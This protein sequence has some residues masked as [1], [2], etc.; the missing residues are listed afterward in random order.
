MLT[1]AAPALPPARESRSGL[2]AL[3]LAIAI[4]SPAAGLGAQPPL[5]VRIEATVDA[6]T[7]PTAGRATLQLRFLA[8]EP[9]TSPYAVRVE[10]RA[11]RRTFLRRDHAPPQPTTRWAAG[12]ATTYDLPLVFPLGPPADARGPIEVFVGLVDPATD[13]VARLTGSAGLVRVAT[14]VFEAGAAPDVE[15]VV[16][17]ALTAAA[18]E[19]QT[20]WDQLEYAFRRVD[21]YPAKAKLQKALLQVGRMPPA[22]LSFEETDIVQRRIQEERARYLRLCAGR[23][24]DRGRLLGALL[25]LDEVGGRL[26]EEADRAVLGALAGAQRVTQDRAAIADKVFALSGEQRDEVAQLVD[27]HPGGKE[28]LAA[29]VR[30]ARDP[31]HR[32]VGRELVRTLEFTP[33]LRAEARAAREQIERAWLADV[34]AD[35]RAE[36][37]AALQHP[38]WART[39]VRPSHRFVLIGPQRLLDGVPADSLLRFDLAYLYLTDLFG[40]VPNPAGDRVTV[41][42]KELWDFGGGQGGGKV[43][44]IGRADPQAEA[45]RVDTGLLYHEL[46]HC[47]EDVKPVYAGFKEGLADFGAAFALLE[48]GQVAAG[49][50]AIG[51][52]QRAFLQDYLERDLEYWRIPNYGPSAG[53]L[54]HFVIAHGRDGDGYRWDLYRRFFR[55]YAACPVGDARAPNIARAFAHHLV[56]AFGEAAFADLQRFRWPLLDSDLEAVRLEQL[57]AAKRQLGPDLVGFAG[58]PVPRDRAAAEL[59]RRGAGLDAHAARLGIVRDWWIVGP[60]RRDGVDV[61]TYRFPP[62]LEIDLAARYESIQHSPTWRRP[63][64]RPVTVRG[65]GWIDFEFAY[66]EDSAFYALT[67]VRAERDLDAWFHLRADDDLTLFVDDALVDKFGY[68]DTA[69]GPWR[70]G[71]GVLLPDAIRFQVPLAAGRHKVLVKVRNGGGPSGFALAIAQRNGEP[72]GGWATD[73]EPP[74]RPRSGVELPEARRWPSRWKAKFADAAAAKKLQA[75]VGGF[76]VRGGALEG[77][78]DGRQVE[79]RKYTVRPGFPKDSPSNLAW[80][81]EKATESLDALELTVELDADQGPPKLAVILQGDGLRDALAGWTLILEP[82]GDGVR[83]FLERYDRRVHS[84]GTQA[85]PRE[86]KGPWPLVVTV[87]ANRVSVRLA[88]VLLFDQ[89]PIRPI[90]GRHRLGIATWGDKPRLREIELRAPARTR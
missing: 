51:L 31:R 85:L 72:L 43:I 46:T 66:Q 82:A 86:A 84:T 57:A 62:E 15:A 73:A 90:P 9:L 81:P 52:A 48:L 6:A 50:A 75:T 12:V 56:Q 78:D 13:E 63:G 89:A 37:E 68:A 41:Y 70:P 45:V 87:Y 83:A 22:P 61:D 74:A 3:V 11:G 47:V 7:L 1:P 67:H 38:A 53:F 58:S 77:S 34:P 25:L 24:Y 5:P 69:T 65:T 80:L 21:A 35:E 88:G 59:D 36:A 29:G 28:R 16:R 4:A 14:F 20:A 40:R 60:F 18:K 64:P 17:A 79:W 30:L 76:R 19:P 54:L 23:M 71:R 42:F 33:E 27:K 32:A 55:D 49:R 44:D 10:L 26:Q 8:T 39:A 2:R